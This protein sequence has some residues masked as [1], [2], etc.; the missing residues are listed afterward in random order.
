MK[1]ISF[2]QINRDG[3]IIAENELFAQYHTKEMLSRYD[4]NLLAFKR[5]PS[6]LELK[7]AEQLLHTHHKQYGQKHLKFIFP[8]NE[9]ISEEVIEYLTNERYT[10]GFLELYS[11]E[12][13]RF[14]ARKNPE[15]E[16]RFASEENLAAV[17]ELNYKEDL[18]YGENFAKE[19]QEHLQRIF[20]FED[21]YFVIAYV[22][23]VP[24][25]FLHLIEQ[26]ETVEIDNF[27]VPDSM[28][29]KGIGSQMQQFVMDHFTEKTIILVADGEDTAREMYRKQNYDY[30]G[31]QYEA[32]KVV[33]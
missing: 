10:I 7:E 29:R 17:L 27:F 12:P 33:E 26:P 31:F 11:I 3:S 6:L 2:A 8:S 22:D 4:S 9:K 16:V 24:A 13:T 19:K 5:M 18:Q 25:G 32:L 14:S 23:G 1:T 20:T 30:L 21:R 28:Q 15:V